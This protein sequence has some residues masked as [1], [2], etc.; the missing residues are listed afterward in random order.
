MQELTMNKPDFVNEQGS[1][2]WRNESLDK[3]AKEKG[4]HGVTCWLVEAKSG[5]REFVI[6]HDNQP[7]YSSPSFEHMAAH[8]DFMWLQEIM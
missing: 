5:Q 3:Y 1:K 8:I 7:E 2:W 6:L 4:L